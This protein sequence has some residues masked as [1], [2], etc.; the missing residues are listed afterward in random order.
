MSYNPKPIDTAAVEL[1]KGM[2]TVI[3]DLA[4]NTHDAWARQ[5]LSEGWKYGPHRDDARKE[6][7]CL[8]PYDT[9]PESEK[10]YDR[11]TAGQTLKSIVALGY[12]IG[13]IS[14]WQSPPQ[15]IRVDR[16]SKTLG[17]SASTDE[18]T[19]LAIADDM[20]DVGASLPNDAKLRE[21][22]QLCQQFIVPNFDRADANAR[23]Y[24][25]VQRVTT[26]ISA[27]FGTLAVLLA[28]WEMSRLVPR[29]WSASAEF[30]A[31]MLAAISIFFGVFAQLHERW[32]IERHK[33]ERYRLLKFRRI[34]A[35]I[36]G[37]H[38]SEPSIDEA[39]DQISRLD[40]E[41]VHEWMREESVPEERQNSEG[42]DKRNDP[43]DAV[44]SYYLRNRL[45]G[46][47]QYFANRARRHG[48]W[49]KR[50]RRLPTVLFLGSVLAALLH[51]ATEHRDTGG[52]ADW[53]LFLAAGLPAI[54]AGV[55]A[56]RSGFEFA[57]NTSRFEAAAASLAKLAQR[58]RNERKPEVIYRALVA[59][60]DLL[61]REHREWLRL[62]SDP[63][64]SL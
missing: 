39:S 22:L 44:V 38:D 15:S 5:R 28:I 54:E 19:P 33:S 61:E 40:R 27:V 25:L 56:L 23:L 8:V 10:Q 45:E 41:Q 50:L 46:Q 58:L 37:A 32:R 52:F 63:E 9:L 55:R 60:E 42:A 3:E 36:P 47:R 21:E 26:V 13:P 48:A 6:H 31:V 57:R 34:S 18:E 7:P 12:R 49:D 17:N 1:P 64:W 30:V 16:T 20:H 35:L 29:P 4:R 14:Q 51:F 2:E 59:C 11:L 43:V 53:M 24:G 62:M